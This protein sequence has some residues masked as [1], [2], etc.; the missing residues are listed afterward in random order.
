MY[1]SKPGTKDISYVSLLQNKRLSIKLTLS[2]Q[3]DIRFSTNTYSYNVMIHLNSIML[4]L[5]LL[6]KDYC[7]NIRK[8]VDGERMRKEQGEIGI[9]IPRNHIMENSNNKITK[10]IPVLK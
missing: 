8:M 3:Y 2:W 7:N 9:P 5:Q 10:K 1:T 6:L 4:D